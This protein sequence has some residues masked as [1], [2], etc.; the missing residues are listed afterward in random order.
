V[1]L[2]EQGF[3][4]G[5]V[6]FLCTLLYVGV[7]ILF[8]RVENFP[9]LNLKRLLYLELFFFSALGF[10]NDLWRELFG[11]RSGWK[12]WRRDRVGDRSH[13]ELGSATASLFHLALYF[14]V[15]FFVGCHRSL[16]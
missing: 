13:P 5:T 2:I 7:M 15:G 12:R 10:F 11:A 4:W 16:Q 9:D 1:K 3:G 14:G 8:R 6:F